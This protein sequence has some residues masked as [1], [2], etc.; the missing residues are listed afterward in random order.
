MKQHR[1]DLGR[2]GQARV[3][4]AGQQLCGRHLGHGPRDVRLL[5]DE[6]APLTRISDTAGDGVEW[7]VDNDLLPFTSLLIEPAKVLFLNNAINH[8][9]LTPLG[10]TEAA[11]EGQVDPVPARGQPGSRVSA[12]CWPTRSSARA[13]AKASA[14]GAAIIQFF[15][16]IHEIYFPYVLMKPKLIIAMIAGGMTQIFVLVLFDTGLRAP[17]APGSVIAVYAQTPRDSVV[18]VTLSILGGHSSDLHRRGAAPQDRQDRRGGGPAGQRHPRHGG[19]EGSGPVDRVDRARRSRHRGPGPIR[20]IVFACDAG[21]GSSAM[22]ASVLRRKVHG[23]GFTDVTV[24]NKAIANLTDDLRRG[25]QPPGPDRPR[26]ASGPRRRCTSRWRTSWT[27]RRTTRSSRSSGN[28]TVAASASAAAPEEGP[29]LS[30]SLLSRRLDRPRR[31]RGVA[32]RRD[33]PGGRAA[34]RGRG[35]GLVVR[36]RDACPGA[37]GLDL[38]G[39]PARAAA[40]DQ[41]GQGI[42]P[43]DRGV[44]RALRRTGGLERQ[45]GAVRDRCGRRG[46]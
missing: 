4:D 2:Q 41:R 28:A 32:R 5:R 31:H 45:A 6:P 25:R 44:V 30:G 3:R 14:P 39:Q 36:R 24:I 9:V 26:R 21:M 23:A 29:D 27:A 16:G 34:R 15:G 8:G 19:D 33:H 37:V 22:G 1:R 13:L 46:R 38:H 43:A 11:R 12:C 17:A 7:L 40:R 10:T 42:D 18:G 20:N 35:R